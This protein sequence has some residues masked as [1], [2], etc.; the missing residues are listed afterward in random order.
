[1]PDRRDASNSEDVFPDFTPEYS[2]DGK[3]IIRLTP[4]GGM[5]LRD[6]FA[7]QALSGLIASGQSN[8]LSR[9]SFALADRMIEERAQGG[10]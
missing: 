9:Q 3:H 1:M 7:G 4:Y 6:Y 5:S 10:A 8:D 2:D